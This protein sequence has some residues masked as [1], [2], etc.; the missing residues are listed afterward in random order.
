MYGLVLSAAT[1]AGLLLQTEVTVP[2]Y[3]GRDA[4][5]IAVWDWLFRD[6]LPCRRVD[7][8]RTLQNVA[9]GG[10]RPTDNG[11]GG[12]N[13]DAQFGLGQVR[14][15]HAHGT[16]IDGPAAAVARRDD[17]DE[18]AAERIIF[19]VVEVRAGID[20]AGQSVDEEIRGAQWAEHRE[21]I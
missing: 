8:S 9:N 11:A 10:R 7:I 5:R 6:R 17:G 12:G 18:S 20:R 4:Q 16:Q 14:G 2:V 13:F 15:S 21:S 1:N 19:D 3:R